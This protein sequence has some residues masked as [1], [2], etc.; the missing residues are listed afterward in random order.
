M[1]T[2][3]TKNIIHESIQHL[4]TFKKTYVAHEYQE[5]NQIVDKL[6]N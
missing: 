6:A 4:K 2:W 3:M 1:P 5:A